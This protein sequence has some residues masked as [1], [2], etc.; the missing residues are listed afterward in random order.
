MSYAVGPLE[1]TLLLTEGIVL[2]VRFEAPDL[3]DEWWALALSYANTFM[4]FSIVGATAPVLVTQKA[5][6]RRLWLE[7]PPGAAS[8]TV[9]VTPETKSALLTVLERQH[10]VPYTLGRR[11]PAKID[12]IAYTGD[13]TR[14]GALGER[15]RHRRRCNCWGKK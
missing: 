2:S 3:G 10:F 11:G 8:H 6:R 13:G 14:L 1:S 9:I 7:G 4:K 15:R 5:V 12:S